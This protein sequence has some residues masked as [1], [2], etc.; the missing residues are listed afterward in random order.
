MKRYSWRVD[1]D[2]Y[3]PLTG[4][5]AVARILEKAYR[6]RDLCV[7]HVSS[8]FYGGVWPSCSRRRL[9]LLATSALMPTGA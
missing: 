3:A 4:D 7:L 2:D 5:D 8:T 6:L 1:I 9:C